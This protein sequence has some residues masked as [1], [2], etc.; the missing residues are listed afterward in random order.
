MFGFKKKAKGYIAYFQLE[1]LWFNYLN[2]T[3]RR[4]VRERFSKVMSSAGNPGDSVDQVKIDDTSMHLE[5]FLSVAAEGISDLEKKKHIIDL[6]LRET[7]K[8]NDPIRIH[9]AY[10]A[11][12]RQY[13]LMIKMNHRHNDRFIDILNKDCSIYDS[14]IK[15]YYKEKEIIP[16]YPAFKELALAYER[17]G[18]IN[19]A[20]R[21]SKVA[22]LKNVNEKTSFENRIQ[23]LQQKLT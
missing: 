18:E 7:E 4:E 11:A 12:A 13:K 19:K 15:S 20:I 2:D 3:D 5:T 17:K 8:S 9:Y 22:L 16:S 1:D 23:K 6:A 10:L 14:F 21:I